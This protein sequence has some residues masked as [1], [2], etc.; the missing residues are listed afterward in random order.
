MPSMVWFHSGGDPYQSGELRLLGLPALLL[1][2]RGWSCRFL[3]VHAA[4]GEPTDLA[5]ISAGAL[6]ALAQVGGWARPPMIVLSLDDAAITRDARQLDAVQLAAGRID[7]V[8]ARGPVAERWARANLADRVACAMIPDIAEREVEV[9]AAAVRF[10]IPRDRAPL[11]IGAG[12]GGF[13]F[14]GPGDIVDEQEILFVLDAARRAA[15]DRA[16]LV[17]VAPRAVLDWLYQAGLD[18]TTAVQ[19]WT[20]GLVDRLIADGASVVLPDGDGAA[21]RRAKLVRHGMTLP[22]ADAARFDPWA[23]AGQWRD[24]LR[25]HIG[26]ERRP[27]PS[28]HTLLLFIDLIQDVELA[29]PIIDVVLG[30]PRFT[31]RLVASAWL[32]QQHPRLASS[33]ATRGI[34][35][36]VH[37]RKAIMNLGTVPLDGVDA[38]LTIVETTLNPHKRAHAL[39]LQAQ[40]IGIPAFTMQ[41]GLENVGLTYFDDVHDTSVDIRSDYI[42]AWFPSEDVPP[43]VPERVRPRLLHVGRPRMP[44]PTPPALPARPGSR[45]IAVFENLHW[46]RYSAAFR[47]QFISDCFQLAR[48]LE[49]TVV[50]IKPHPA[51]KWL[52]KSRDTVANWPVNILVADPQDPLWAD[53]TAA[54][55]I[56]SADAVITTPSSVAVDAVIDGKRV[57]VVGYD[58]D[59]SSYAPLPILRNFDDWLGF[60]TSREAG[61]LAA[62]ARA[63]FLG[64]IDI[65]GPSEHRLVQAIDAVLANRL[66]AAAR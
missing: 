5:V 47:G 42:F 16:P 3:P 23:V 14:A 57:A 43:S 46:E 24:L 39:T 26:A 17:L 60:A 48:V 25:R 38:L 32:M 19:P 9:R 56:A 2:E 6:G 31:L 54:S 7:A 13:W 41:H 50:V 27:R 61:V 4:R 8:V 51:G 18:A 45:T 53:T 22:V 21:R 58:L 49:D 65:S 28:R 11:A 30:H 40:A 1:E 29:L 12:Y 36:E 59:V 55:L 52:V 33:L 20:S 34:V 44:A 35:P 15:A 37:D 63:R 10:G 62:Q 64:R 66:I